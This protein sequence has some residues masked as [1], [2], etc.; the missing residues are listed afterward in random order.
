MACRDLVIGSADGGC[1]ALKEGGYDIYA[2]P[3]VTED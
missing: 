3:F 1:R 2:S